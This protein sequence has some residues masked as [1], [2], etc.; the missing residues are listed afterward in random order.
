M[1]WIGDILFTRSS[2]MYIWIAPT[3][4]L[5]WIELLWTSYCLNACFEFFRAYAQGVVLL[6]NSVFAFLRKLQTFPQWL[7]HF[8]F[9]AAMYKGSNF[10]TSLPVLVIF[11]LTDFNHPS[12]NEVVSCY[13]WICISLIA[14]DVEHLLM[15]VLVI[16]VSSLEKW[17][18]MSFAQFSI[19]EL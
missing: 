19:V 4:W 10:F 6:G 14:K 1:G 15:D 12:G 13:G 8:S 18:F 5:L 3:Q 7:H 2:S 9:P 16:C 11:C 17:L